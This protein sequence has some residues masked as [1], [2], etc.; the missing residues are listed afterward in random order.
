MSIVL[1]TDA[2]IQGKTLLF[3][4]TPALVTGGLL[5][6]DDT[7]AVGYVRRKVIVLSAAQVNALFTTFQPLVTAKGAGT[8]IRILSISFKS[9][10][11]TTAYVSVNNLEFRYTNASGVKV[12]ADI[13]AATLAYTSGTRYAT[14]GGVITEIQP[15][16]N[17]AVVVCVPIADPTLGDSPVTFTIDYEVVTF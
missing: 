7:I 15:A 1:N 13:A 10:F 12:S 8:F 4:E 16:D 3:L 11:N 9:V 6:A 5:P 14:V 2:A 17:A